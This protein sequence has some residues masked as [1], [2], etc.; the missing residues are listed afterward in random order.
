MK[1]I[2]I[3]AAPRMEKGNTQIVLNPFLVGARG[4][5]ATVDIALLAK[6]NIKPCIGCFT[7]Y[8]KTPG[9]CVHKDDMEALKERIT[10]ADM[11]VLA[12]PVYLDGMTSLSKMFVDRLVS[13]L[14]PHFVS[15][16]AG[17][18]HPLRLR[19]PE[20]LFLVSICGYPGI[21]N[22]EPL[23]FHM[24]RIARNLHSEFCGALLRPAAFSLLLAKKYPERVKAILDATRTAGEELVKGGRI[25]QNIL[26]EVAGDICTSEELMATANSYWDRELSRNEDEPA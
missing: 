5:G 19:F 11:L 25:S 14:D 10:A 13:F 3:N 9:R 17:L 16:G 2:V 20:K 15:D 18:R 4:A 7:C 12:T 6:K 24:Q 8:A 21:H 1:I 23:V 22:F 26:D